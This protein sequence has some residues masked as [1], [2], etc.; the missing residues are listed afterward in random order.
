M[1]NVIEETQNEDRFLQAQN[2]SETVFQKTVETHKLI[3]RNRA[4]KRKLSSLSGNVSFVKL[5]KSIKSLQKEKGLSSA[6]I[7][8][9]RIYVELFKVLEMNEKKYQDLLKN[10]EELGMAN[11]NFQ[12]AIFRD[13]GKLQFLESTRQSEDENTLHTFTRTI[14]TPTSE[15][16]E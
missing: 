13:L 5:D 11:S 8:L 9:S 12:S 16:I 2:L 6:Q 4:K 3:K 10:L 15:F 14:V 1:E 7:K